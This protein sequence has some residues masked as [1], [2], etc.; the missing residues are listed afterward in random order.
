MSL[1]C[2]ATPFSRLHPIYG[3][4]F[5]HLT[6]DHVLDPTTYLTLIAL[7]LSALASY[8]AFY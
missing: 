3:T 4:S 7:L 2:L 5:V 6:H 8:I 1:S